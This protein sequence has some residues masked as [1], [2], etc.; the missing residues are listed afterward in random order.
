MYYYNIHSGSGNRLYLQRKK[1]GF[2]SLHSFFCRSILFSKANTSRL[3]VACRHHGVT[4]QAALQTASA[5][6]LCRLLRNPNLSTNINA[7][8]HSLPLHIG[9]SVDMR[10]FYS[11][12]PKGAVRCYVSMKDTELNVS[13]DSEFW[14]VAQENKRQIH[15][16]PQESISDF[17]KQLELDQKIGSGMPKSL[18]SPPNYGCYPG[19][20]M[21]HSNLGN[22]SILE[23]DDTASVRI[24]GMVVTCSMHCFGPIF[25]HY[26]M[27]ILD[28]LNL[29][30]VHFPNIH[31]PDVVDYFVSETQ[32]ILFDAMGE[33]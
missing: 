11:Q 21:C 24:N 26:A 28:Q 33:T 32:R 13:W 20:R 1:Y 16:N 8:P 3:A 22:C 31:S 6:A 15:S 17:L 10:N 23:L 29:N 25:D 18:P 27:T 9:C 4:V 19:L 30:I 14:Q 7:L 2:F 5:I 12:I